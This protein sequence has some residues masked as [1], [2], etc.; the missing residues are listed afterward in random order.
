MMNPLLVA[1]VGFALF[2]LCPRMAGMANVI[3]KATNSNLVL[4][5]V[6]GTLISLPLIVLMALIFRHYGLWAAMAFAVLTDLLAALMMGAISWKASLETFIIAV[7]VI[8]G[9]KVA[10]LISAKLF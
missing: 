10:G 4:V 6:I 2:I 5:A 3:T 1:S 9:V 8:A 7:F